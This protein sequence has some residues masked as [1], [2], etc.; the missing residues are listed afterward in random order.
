[1]TSANVENREKLSEFSLLVAFLPIAFVAAL[2]G[3]SWLGFVAGWRITSVQPLLALAVTLLLPVAFGKKLVRLDFSWRIFAALAF[4]V[5]LWIAIFI[6]S[7]FA[8]YSCDGQG[9]HGTGVVQ[10]LEGW[11]PIREPGRADAPQALQREVMIHYAKGPWLS[12]ATLCKLVGKVEAGKATTLLVMAGCFFL[13]LHAGL[14]FSQLGAMKLFVLSTLV[15]LNPISLN[16]CLTFY[17]DG[18]LAAL[19]TCMVLSSCLQLGERRAITIILTMLT[20]VLLINIKLTALVYVSVFGFA[21]SIAVCALK[22]V[23]TLPSLAATYAIGIV[24]GLA[25]G[26]NPYVTNVRETGNPFFPFTLEQTKRGTEENFL[27]HQMPTTFRG[28]N[29]FDTFVRSVFG[30]CWNEYDDSSQTFTGG[31]LKIPFTVGADE[32]RYF[33]NAFDIRI[34]GWGP[35]TSGVLLFALAASFF[36]MKDDLREHRRIVVALTLCIL[37]T[38]FAMPHPWYARYVPQLWLLPVM[39]AAILCLSKRKFPNIL[40][41]VLIAFMLANLAI[42]SV[43]S[44]RTS[45]AKTRLLNSQLKWL[46]GQN[47]VY[48]VAFGDYVFNRRRFQEWGIRYRSVEALPPQAQ[49]LVLAGDTSSKTLVSLEE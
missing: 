14:R 41:A 38:I 33:D 35:L 46:A 3:F 48:T 24:L 43:P 21:F 37:A 20:I 49:Q 25:I 10:L 42:V 2:V 22:K 27:V 18:Q 40:G 11:N 1:M 44:F 31:P 5:V 9:Y 39:A 8:D 30:R 34:C 16:Q 23:N 19:F 4:G 36:G 12:A 17:V 7:S 6:S 15:A 28:R 32:I 47:R 45:Y 29:R 26:Y 13:A